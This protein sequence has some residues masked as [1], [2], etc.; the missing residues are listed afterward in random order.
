[1]M[2]WIKS[3]LKT[4]ATLG[5]LFGLTSC[6]PENKTYDYFMQ[7]PDIVQSTLAECDT[8]SSETCETARRAEHD[9]QALM[10]DRDTDPERF[11]EK[12]L[13]AENDLVQKR[14]D[15]EHAKAAAENAHSGSADLNK[16]VETLT[17]EYHSQL[18][19]VNTLLAVVAAG[20]SP[21]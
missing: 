11:G 16:T 20:G 2:K 1:M 19:N 21:Q 15:L 18:E 3:F 14:L 9:F 6:Q 12:I 17:D 8:N 4:S 13:L 10:N 5:L 7:H